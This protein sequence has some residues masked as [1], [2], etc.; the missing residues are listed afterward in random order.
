MSEA[1]GRGRDPD[2]EPDQGGP[3]A[4][5]AT[6]GLAS[7]GQGERGVGD[8]PGRGGRRGP[9]AGQRGAGRRGSDRRGLHPEP[10]CG[11]RAAGRADDRQTG[12]LSL[13]PVRQPGG[14]VE[15]IS[16][17][18]IVDEA[19]GLVFPAR[20]RLTRT[21]LGLAAGEDA[22]LSPGMSATVEVVTGR[23]RVMDFLWSP[24][25]KAVGTAGRKR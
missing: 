18:E 19:R 7:V 9:G 23:R 6:A 13:H 20:I 17:D 11:L 15:H 22:V 25:P 2:R 4:I 21:Q 16:P 5:A 14:V 8:D 1:Q 24:V 10:R 3:A 12:G